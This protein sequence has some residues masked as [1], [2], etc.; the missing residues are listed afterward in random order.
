M[1]NLVDY[2]MMVEVV[3]QMVEHASTGYQMKVI[4]MAFKGMNDKSST[5]YGWIYQQTTG[6]KEY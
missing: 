3:D 6:K 4:R 5:N 2:L 1:A